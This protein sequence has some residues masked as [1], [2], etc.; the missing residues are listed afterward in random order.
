[1]S[2]KDNDTRHNS[3]GKTEVVFSEMESLYLP[4]ISRFKAG[5]WPCKLHVWGQLRACHPAFS[6]RP[7]KEKLTQTEGAAELL[8]KVK[9]FTLIISQDLLSPL[10]RTALCRTLKTSSTTQRTQIAI[11]QE[12]RGNGKRVGGVE[13]LRSSKLTV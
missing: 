8:L 1:M 13:K 9:T 4:F 10:K 6:R 5:Q 2:R 11:N 7:P 12:K 3:D